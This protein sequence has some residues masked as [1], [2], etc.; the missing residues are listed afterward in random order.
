MAKLTGRY[1]ILFEDLFGVFE[2]S[3]FWGSV[4][5]LGMIHFAGRLGG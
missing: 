2:K 5:F 1:K 3:E 4:M